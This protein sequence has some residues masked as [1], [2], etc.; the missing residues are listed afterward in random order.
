M[1][2]ILTPKLNVTNI[3]DFAN[4]TGHVLAGSNTY[5][6]GRLSWDPSQTSE[7]VNREWSKLSFP[8]K[9][10]LKP[11]ESTLVVDTITD[12]LQKSREIYEGYNAPL[13]ILIL[14]MLTSQP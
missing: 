14:F 1:P 8:A 2:A 12:I 11:A 6:F 10:G 13:G 4:W 5:G 9:E 7:E 3:G